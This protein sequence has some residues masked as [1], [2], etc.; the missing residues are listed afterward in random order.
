MVLSDPKF[1]ESKDADLPV[2]KSVTYVIDALIDHGT[3]LLT[4]WPVTRSSWLCVRL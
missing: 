2:H 4:P 3:A 1:E